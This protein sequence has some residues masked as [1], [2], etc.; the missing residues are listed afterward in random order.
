MAVLGSLLG[1][2]LIHAGVLV[3]HSPRHGVE[4]EQDQP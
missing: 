1:L 2:Q 4:V 3:I